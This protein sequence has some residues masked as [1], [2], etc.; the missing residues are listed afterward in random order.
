VFDGRRPDPLVN[1]TARLAKSQP[2]KRLDLGK[3][4]GTVRPALVHY[5]DLHTR[6]EPHYVD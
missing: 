2:E 1:I 5:K 3:P 4:C 6:P